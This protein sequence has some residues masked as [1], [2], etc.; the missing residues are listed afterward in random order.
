MAEQNKKKKSGLHKEISLIFDG[1]PVPS[2]KGPAGPKATPPGSGQ[3]RAAYDSPRPIR[4]PQN[5]QIPGSPNFNQPGGPAAAARP[6]TG[7]AD[8]AANAGPLKRMT[9]KLFAPK[10]GVNPRKQK[11]LLLAIPLLALVLVVIA[12]NNLDFLFSKPAATVKQPTGNDTTQ[13][14]GMLT[15]ID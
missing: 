12:G 11:M 10:P 9:R 8:Q 5:P 14:A 15:G 7:P 6:K 2:H 13:I 4:A 3:G 1:V